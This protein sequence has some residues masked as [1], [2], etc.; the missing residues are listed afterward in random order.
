M[1]QNGLAG[2]SSDGGGSRANNP[3]FYALLYDPGAIQDARYTSLARSQISRMYHSTAAL[4][5]EVRGGRGI[6]LMI[7]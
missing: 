6:L 4:T 5:V 3:T 7:L 1:P 2:D